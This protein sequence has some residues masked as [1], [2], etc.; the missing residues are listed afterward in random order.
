[1]YNE[2]TSILKNSLVVSTQ[3]VSLVGIALVAPLFH[4][5]LIAG[6]IVNA[7]LFVATLL[8]GI[9]AG[10]MVGLLPSLIALSVGT[11]PTPL[12]PM[13]PYIMLAN[14]SLVLAFGYFKE[15]NFWLAVAVAS[16]LKF[17][18]LFVTSSFV[19]SLFLK[20]EL[21]QGILMMMSWP[22]LLTAFLGGLI[23]YF[24]LKFYGRNK[25]SDS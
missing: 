18:F 23:A 6:S 3:L 1:M 22:Q 25:N 13:I 20:K 11:L 17:V 16:L 8:F 21:T 4:Q 9:Q 24:V 19:V 10:I 5:Q 14:I 12:A 15:K 7:T 2:Q